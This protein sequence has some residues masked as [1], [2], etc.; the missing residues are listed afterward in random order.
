VTVTDCLDAVTS[1]VPA[2]QVRWSIRRRDN[3]KRQQVS[4]TTVI[5]SYAGVGTFLQN[6]K[7]NKKKIVPLNK[8]WFVLLVLL[9]F[10]NSL[11]YAKLFMGSITKIRLEICLT[12]LTYYICILSNHVYC[13][14]IIILF[15]VLLQYSSVK[16][17]P[18]P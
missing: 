4:A 13:S 15:A 8:C 14:Y 17:L 7:C 2:K 3:N 1:I 16:K 10:L 6:R 18:S 5:N 12:W 9:Q 11:E